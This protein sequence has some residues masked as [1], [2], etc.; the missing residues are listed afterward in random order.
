MFILKR[1]QLAVA[2]KPIFEKAMRK[3]SLKRT[4]ILD[5]TSTVS[6]IGNS[7]LFLGYDGKKELQFSRLR[8]SFEKFMPRIIIILSKNETDFEYK[9]RYSLLSSIVVFFWA[10][11]SIVV[12]VSALVNK[13]NYDS[14][15]VPLFFLVSFVLLT[16]LEFKIVS[17]RVDKALA[18]PT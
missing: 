10:S 15:F 11:G 1:I 6:D 9:F 13:Y 17:K 18:Q 3:S 4:W 8:T 12:A 16:W 2:E 14:I 7:K 5:F